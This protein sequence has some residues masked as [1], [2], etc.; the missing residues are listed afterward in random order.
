[1]WGIPPYR[2]PRDILRW[3][4]QQIIDLGVHVRLNT[5]VGRDV[6]F[7]DILQK[8]DSVFLGIGAQNDLPMNLPNEDK[9]GVLNGM[10]LLRQMNLGEKVDL[11]KRLLVI[12]GGNVSVDVARTAHRLGCEK[13]I[14]AYRREEIDM[15]AYPEEIGEAKKE[16]IEFYFLLAP[17]KIVVEKGRAAGVVFRKMKMDEF[18]K[19]GRRKPVPV[20]YETVT[21]M[22]DQIVTAIG[23]QIDTEFA[24]E[25]AG[26]F[27]NHRQRIAVEPYTMETS[28]PRV[29]AGGDAVLGP[30]T[31]IEAVAH[32]KNAARQ[33]DRKLMGEDRLARLQG[34]TQFEYSMNP[35]DN[36]EPI[37][38]ADI[39]T[40]PPRERACNFREVVMCLDDQCA[41]MEAK[42][43]LRCDIREGV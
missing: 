34:L 42:R 15:P 32:G 33:M 25:M 21:I 9:P 4:I 10:K 16:G 12:G 35:P 26:Q 7:E 37:P 23:Q 13:V 1:M 30:A 3:E 18:T 43:C 38:R 6:P 20:E 39:L 11:G 27:M 17:E 19:W 31:V 24:G 29:F 22:A 40:I 36:E 14:I 28:H 8:Y 41:V 5:T 2:L